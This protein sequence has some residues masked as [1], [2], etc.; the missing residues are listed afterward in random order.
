LAI[1]HFVNL[2]LQAPTSTK[3]TKTVFETEY[4]KVEPFLYNVHDIAKYVYT[5]FRRNN[6]HHHLFLHCPNC[7]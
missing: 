1:E 6:I 3:T 7:W 4:A 2:L 5:S